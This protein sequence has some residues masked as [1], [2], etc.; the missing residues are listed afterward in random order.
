METTNK[1]QIHN[2]MKEQLKID[3]MEKQTKEQEIMGKSQTG[4]REACKEISLTTY[5]CRCEK[6]FNEG[7]TQAISDEIEFLRSCLYLTKDKK[8]SLFPRTQGMIE[9]RLK[10]LLQEIKA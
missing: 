1:K 3:L 10:E 4:F 9:E 7:R 8:V 6:C 2:D 5:H